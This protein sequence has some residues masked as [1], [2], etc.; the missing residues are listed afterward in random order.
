MGGGIFKSTNTV[1]DLKEIIEEGTTDKYVVVDSSA[2]EVD[3]PQGWV[4][5]YVIFVSPSDPDGAKPCK[6]PNSEIGFKWNEGF[7]DCNGKKITISPGTSVS[8][9]SDDGYEHDMYETDCYW[10]PVSLIQE[11]TTEFSL[12]LTFRKTTYLRCNVHPDT[13]RLKVEVESEKNE[14]S[15]PWNYDPHSSTEETMYKASLGQCVRFVSTDDLYHGLITKNSPE[16]IT[17]KIS[18]P[19][20]YK[21][22]PK[23]KGKYHFT[24]RIYGA[25]I[26]VCINVK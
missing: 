14:V 18:K 12:A 7:S 22:Y 11:A 9:V 13:M 24:C 4:N 8:F 17:T 21:F 20:T 6:C 2:T 25:K 10:N 1:C 23:K 16:S 15:V 26:S 5:P 3:L 19:M